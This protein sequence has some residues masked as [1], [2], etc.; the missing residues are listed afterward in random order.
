VKEEIGRFNYDENLVSEAFNIF[1]GLWIADEEMGV[2]FLE[3][4]TSKKP[5]VSL[6]TSI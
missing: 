4:A 1:G 5:V 6:W 3:K 2:N